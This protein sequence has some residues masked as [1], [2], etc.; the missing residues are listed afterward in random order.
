MR[1][2]RIRIRLCSDVFLFII[3]TEKFCFSYEKYKFHFAVIKPLTEFKAPP[4][5]LLN[6]VLYG[7]AP[8]ARSKPLPFHIPFLREKVST[9]FVYLS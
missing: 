4:E 5:G 8:R 6:K 7:E 2:A 1:I 9:P 3:G